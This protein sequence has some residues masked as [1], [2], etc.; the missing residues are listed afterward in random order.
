[1]DCCTSGTGSSSVGPPQGYK[2][3]QQT[4]SSMISS[5]HRAAGPARSLFQCGLPTGS[6]PPLG[7]YLLQ[8]LVLHQE[9]SCLTTSCRGISALVPGAAPPPP[10]ALTSV[11]AELFLLKCSLSQL[12]LPLCPVSPQP[13]LLNTLSQR[14]DKWQRCCHC[15]DGLSLGLWWVPLGPAW[16]CIC[17]TQWKFLAASHRSHPCSPPLPKACHADSIRVNICFSLQLHC[18]KTCIGKIRV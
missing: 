14:W 12:H 5:L 1:M 3:C 6:Q 15:S 2:S 10:S 8:C 9:H 17:Q 11:S 7:I 18:L 16:H 4:C 13:C